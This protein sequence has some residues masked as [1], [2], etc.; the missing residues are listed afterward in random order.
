MVK[1]NIKFINRDGHRYDWDN[2]DIDEKEVIREEPKK[3]LSDVL[4]EIPEIELES[5]YDKF[6]GPALAPPQE[7]ATTLTTDVALAQVNAGL[8][9]N[10]DEDLKAGVVEGA[11]PDGPINLTQDDSDEESYAGVKDEPPALVTQYEDDSNDDESD[12]GGEE[13]LADV[14]A[15]TDDGCRYPTCRRMEP[16][17]T[18]P[19]AKFPTHS[20]LR[21]MAGGV[22]SA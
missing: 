19:L 20:S 6:I 7:M 15:I 12:N 18:I 13:S 17:R 4:A 9:S 11:V 22:V 3:V 1:E 2:D 16:D 14:I 5:D 21:Q 10:S 8:A